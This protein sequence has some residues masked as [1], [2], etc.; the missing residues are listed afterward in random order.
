ML[1]T[2]I[3]RLIDP[4]LDCAGAF[5][6]RHNI[7]PNIITGIGMAF[8]CAC[9]AALSFGFY[10]LALLLMIT[11]R[12][13]DGLDGAAARHSKN[14]ATDL[15]GFYD[16]VADM[17]FYAGFV[18][19]F[20]LGRPEDALLAGFLIFSFMGTSSSFLAFAIIAAKRDHIKES[21]PQE[22]GQKSFFYL[23]GLTEG[24]ETI[25]AFILICCLPDYFKL[26]ALIFAALCWLTTAGRIMQARDSFKKI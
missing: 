14:G 7:A 17:I 19:F 6:A 13:C 11:S 1:D 21:V 23:G 22:T 10:T 20:A 24:S 25:I 18:F 3:R 26:I 9:F 5:L 16:I 15:G 4:P 12:I 2:K 8:A